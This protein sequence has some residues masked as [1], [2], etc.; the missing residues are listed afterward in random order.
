MIGRTSRRGERSGEWGGGERE[1]GEE[2]CGEL[3][4]KSLL[5]EWSGLLA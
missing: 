3:D 5:N 2:E 1:E 4:L